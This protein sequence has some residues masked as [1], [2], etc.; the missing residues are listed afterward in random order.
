MVSRPA[1]LEK[2]KRTIPT[3]EKTVVYLFV[4]TLKGFQL[5]H[6]FEIGSELKLIDQII[7]VK[8]HKMKN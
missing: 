1:I 7:K 6:N 2:F 8:N 5:R 3:L 4:S